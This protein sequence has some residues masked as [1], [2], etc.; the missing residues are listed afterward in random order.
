MCKTCSVLLANLDSLD[1]H[2]GEGGEE[3]EV[4]EDGDGD[5]GARVGRGVQPEEEEQLGDEQAQA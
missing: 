1:E 5:A 3:E 2:P 4:H